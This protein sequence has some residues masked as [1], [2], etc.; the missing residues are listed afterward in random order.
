MIYFIIPYCNEQWMKNVLST[1]DEMKRSNHVR[2]Q[3]QHGGRVVSVEKGHLAPLGLENLTLLESWLHRRELCFSCESEFTC[4]PTLNVRNDCKYLLQV[5]VVVSIAMVCAFFNQTCLLIRAD[6][7]AF[8][9]DDPNHLYYPC[10]QPCMYTP[11]ESCL[12]YFNDHVVTMI[13]IISRPGDHFVGFVSLISLTMESSSSL[14][15]LS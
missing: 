15:A 3:L 8:R 7:N 9:F 14:R 10:I 6:R 13:V 2:S 11:N 12:T 5:L 4:H 1:L